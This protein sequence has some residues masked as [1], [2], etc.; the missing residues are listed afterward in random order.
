MMKNEPTLRYYE[1]DGFRLDPHKRLLL[2]DGEPVR[3]K[4]KAFALLL[5]L[6]E[7]RERVL[8]KDELLQAV[9]PDTVVEENNLT[10]HMSA[11]RKALGEKA[12]APGYIV[13]IPGQGYRFTAEV[14]ETPAS[15]ELIVARRAR[16]RVVIEEETDEPSFGTLAVLPF[17]ALGARERD[18]YLELGLADALI[19]RF[20]HLP[21]LILRPT[22]AVARYAGVAHDPI[23]AGRELGV[24]AV[25]DG[26]VQLVGDRLRLT[27][28]LIN[29]GNG[30]MLWAEKFEEQFT[31]IFAIQDS[32]SE[33][34]AQALAL[35]LSSEQRRQLIKHATADTDAYQLYLKGVYY[36]NRGTK[37]GAQKGIEL[38]RQAIEQDPHYACAYAGLADAWCWLSHLFIDP[39][40]ALP[41]ARAAALKALELDETLAEAHLVLGLVKM[42]YEREWAE[43]AGQFKRAL[44]L[45]PHLATAHIWYAFYLAAMGQF[46]RGLAEG[47]LA[48]KLDPFSLNHN[49]LL[50]WVNYFARRYDQALAQF[51]ATAELEPNYFHAYWGLGWTL[52][53]QGHYD[54]A[55]TESQRGL[56]LGGG[57][58]VTAA[59]SHAY[60]KAGRR[61]EARRLLD[62]LYAL[63]KQRYVSPFYLALAHIGLGEIEE[64]FAALQQ[65]CLDRFEWLVQLQVDPVW[66]PLHGD[67]RFA[68]LLRRVGLI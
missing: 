34:V 11:L 41:E 4:S 37:E 26:R 68:E 27:V 18:E 29:T 54:A 56:Q 63:S 66:D 13:T 52:I 62:E 46:E 51:R 23:A 17:K 10:V 40:Q 44:E 20:S 38:F 1:F 7:R 6:I 28:Q 64:T 5:V 33:Q 15:N 16:T 14:A 25:L 55:A 35:R 31:H 67:A 2:R 42:W 65:A 43:C 58:E 24:E 19:T 12:G 8:E 21:Q 32:I 36:T 39:K 57:T 49:A 61:E 9:W 22:S 60:A 50:G 53:Q 48:V 3:L 45:N 59:L 47:E 30:A